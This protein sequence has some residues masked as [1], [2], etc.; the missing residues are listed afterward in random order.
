MNAVQ[1]HEITGSAGETIRV[2]VHPASEHSAA[3]IICHGFKGFKEWGFLPDLADLLA[4][5]GITAVRFDFSHNGIA[6]DITTYERLDLFER[7]T[8]SR[9]LLSLIHI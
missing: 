6:E 1:R 9:E 7:N 4:Q 5:A 2:G 3:V 8:W